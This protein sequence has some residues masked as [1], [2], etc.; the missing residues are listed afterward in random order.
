MGKKIILTAD[1]ALV[2]LMKLCSS[3]EMCSFDLRKKMKLWEIN[4]H[5]Q[6][7]ILDKLREENFFSDQRYAEAFIND[8]L[9]FD[10]WGSLKIKHSLRSKYIPGKIIDQLL[11]E[12]EP[13]RYRE[14]LEDLLQK[15]YNSLKQTLSLQEKKARLYRFAAGRG[16]DSGLIF[17]LLNKIVK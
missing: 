3:K 15:K 8:K 14:I 9:K 13:A 6:N 12:I 5:E 2:R 7:R 1:E 17:E 11:D 10:K 4:E 16:F